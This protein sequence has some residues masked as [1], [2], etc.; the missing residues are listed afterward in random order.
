MCGANKQVAVQINTLITPEN[1]N[2]FCSFLCLNSAPQNFSSFHFKVICILW[3]KPKKYFY[4]LGAK[5]PFSCD[6]LVHEMIVQ[7][8]WWAKLEWLDPLY[9]ST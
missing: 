4:H 7:A 3:Q 8:S 6:L 1:F 2:C 9:H 5:L